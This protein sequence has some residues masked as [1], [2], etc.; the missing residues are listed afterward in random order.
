MNLSEQGGTFEQTWTMET[1]GWIFM[2]GSDRHPPFEITLNGDPATA[3]SRQGHPA[4]HVKK[5]GTFNIK[6]RF[7]WHGLPE[8]IQLPEDNSIT[9][10]VVI[11]GTLHNSPYI[12]KGRLWLRHPSSTSPKRELD[13][14]DIQVFRKITDSVPMFI[15]TIIDLQVSGRAREVPLGWQPPSWL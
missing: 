5:A 8:S 3:V 9:G 11:N 14:V 12:S 4:I 1:G 13:R 6:G 2:P 15:E 7:R 10:P